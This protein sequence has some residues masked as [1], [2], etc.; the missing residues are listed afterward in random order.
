MSNPNPSPENR[1]KEG[2]NANPGGKTKEQKQ[3][4]MEA[5]LMSAKLRHKMLS[6]MTHKLETIPEG[7]EKAPNAMDFLN[8]K[9]LKLFKD[10]EDRYHGAPTQPHEHN[11]VHSPSDKLAGILDAI[12]SRKTS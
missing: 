3:I 7:E 5:A 10:S 6:A 8:N 2:N 12:S 4:E 11:V 1:F 9:S